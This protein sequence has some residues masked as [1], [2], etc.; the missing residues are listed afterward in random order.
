MCP[1]R[2]ASAMRGNSRQTDLELPVFIRV[3][4]F[5]HATRLLSVTGKPRFK[6]S[7][8][9]IAVRSAGGLATRAPQFSVGSIRVLRTVSSVVG[10]SFIEFAVE[11]RAADLEP[12]RG[13]RHLA[14]VMRD[15]EADD[16]VL[17]LLERPH[18]A[19]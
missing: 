15:R 4:R 14:A 9:T 5:C 16:L 3:A 2:A 19:G 1:E 17:H 12:A 10:G 11:S 7:E 18:L 13:L 6:G 8:T